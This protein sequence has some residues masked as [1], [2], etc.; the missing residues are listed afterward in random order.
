MT[1]AILEV[2]AWGSISK[3]CAYQPQRQSSIKKSWV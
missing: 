1:S 2:S 3:T